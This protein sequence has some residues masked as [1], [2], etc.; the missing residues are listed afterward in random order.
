MQIAIE[1][2]YDGALLK[3]LATDPAIFPHVSD[4]YTAN[5]LEWQPLLSELVVNLIAKDD[6]GAFGFGIFLPRTHSCYEVHVGFLPRS[7][8]KKSLTAF[9]VMLSWM[10]KRTKVARI[11]GEIS[12][13]NK[14]AIAFAK[15]AGFRVYGLNLKSRLRGGVL[16]DQVCLG[17]SRP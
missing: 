9:L 4:D 2:T 13:E 7:Y 16:R 17:I 11:V 10:W 12:L 1:R 8:G 5:P 6:E 15:K 14:R 3:K